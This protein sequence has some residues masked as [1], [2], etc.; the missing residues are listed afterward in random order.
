MSVVKEQ[1]ILTI[2]H[3]ANQLFRKY[4][5]KKVTIQEICKE[6]CVS[7]T[8]FYKAFEDKASIA[9][10][11]ISETAKGIESSVSKTCRKSHG[12]KG[13][14]EELLKLHDQF[15]DEIGYDFISETMSAPEEISHILSQVFS[16]FEKNLTKTIRLGQKTG[17][18]SSEININ[19]ALSLLRKLHQLESNAEFIETLPNATKRSNQLSYIFFNGILSR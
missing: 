5:Y 2:V 13:K 18:I 7:K 4:G 17:E 1:K 11:I 10:R 15:V 14:V 6:A 12:V 19:F 3:A 8:T 16:N 9:K